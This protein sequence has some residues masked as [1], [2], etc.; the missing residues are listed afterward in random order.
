L[1]KHK[2]NVYVTDLTNFTALND[3]MADF[4]P[5]PYPARAAIQVSAL[6]KG[7]DV[8]IDAVLFVP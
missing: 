6:P 5:E 2:L 8:E 7:V 3:I 4:L 1:N